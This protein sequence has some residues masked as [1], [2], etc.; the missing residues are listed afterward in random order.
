[1]SETARF[2]VSG[3]QDRVL[4]FFGKYEPLPLAHAGGLLGA[5]FG[6]ATKFAPGKLLYKREIQ[7]ALEPLPHCADAKK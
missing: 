3:S 1:M 6:I 7:R 4:T 2:C 5:L